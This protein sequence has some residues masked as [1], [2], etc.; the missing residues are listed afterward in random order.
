MRKSLFVWAA[1]AGAALALAGQASPA[2]I[3][4]LASLPTGWTHVDINVTINR[5]PHTLVVNRGVVQAAST[6]SL[7]LREADT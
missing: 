3:P 4:N 1:A 2:P 7:T 5:V 6:D